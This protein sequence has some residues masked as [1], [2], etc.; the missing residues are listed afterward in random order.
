MALKLSVP[1][2]NSPEIA[3]DIKDTILT[4]EPN[5]KIDFDME[6]KTVTIEGKASEDTFKQIITATG[7]EVAQS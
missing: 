6:Q 7:H 5:A 1:T 3:Q 4:H 2:L